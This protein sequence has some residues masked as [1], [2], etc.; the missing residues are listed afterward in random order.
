MKWI[1]LTALFLLIG[2]I[3]ILIDACLSHDEQ[4]SVCQC[5]FCTFNQV[6][7]EGE[8]LFNRYMIVI[9]IAWASLLT[10]L[11]FYFSYRMQKPS[12]PRAR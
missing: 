1:V 8:Y 12:K 11:L 5:L 9:S 2:S 3:S 7:E 4:L 10:L 6:P